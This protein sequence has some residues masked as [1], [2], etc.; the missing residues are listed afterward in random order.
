MCEL[1]DI[2]YY[3]VEDLTFSSDL[4]KDSYNFLVRNN[5]F[6]I[7]EHSLRVAQ[8][9]K[10]LARQYGADENLAEVAGLLHDIGGVYTNDKRVEICNILKLN[11]L[12][13]EYA[14]PLILHQ[15]ISV[16]MAQKIFNIHSC[17]ILSAIGCHTTLKAGASSHLEEI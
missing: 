7:A 13:E 14:L 6:R 15:K 16:V 9:A 5:R 17:E 12:P 4:V 8:K 10:I 3:L 1:K 2:F 11:I